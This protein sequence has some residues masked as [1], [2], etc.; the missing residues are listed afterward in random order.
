M[1][2]FLLYTLSLLAACSITSC[3]DDDTTD[4]SSNRMFMTTFRCDNNTGKGDSDP[5]N[6]TIQ[7]LNDAHLYWYTVDGAAGYRIKWALMP[8]VSGGKEAWEEAEANGNLAGDTIVGPD[9]VDLLIK[10]LDYQTDYRFAIQTLHS[11]DKDDPA[12]SKWYGYGD[13]R[14]WA[15]YLGLQ[16]SSRYIVPSVIQA[17]NITK[18]AVRI[19]LNRSANGYSVDE[20]TSFNE[21]FTNDGQNFKVD[22]LTLEASNS[23]PDAKVPAEFARYQLTDQDWNRGYVDIEGLSENSVYVINV[24]D[25]DIKVKVDACYNTLMKRTKGDAGPAILIKHVATM[26]DT[27]GIG[28]N[29]TYYDISAY[30]SMKLDNILND[31]C[32]SNTLA[33][34]QVFYL[35][36]GKTYHCTTNISIYK[37]FTLRTNPKDLA[38]GKGKATLLLNGI[39]QTGTKVN[40]CNFMLGRQPQSGE[41]SSIALD[42]DSVRFMDLNIDVPLAKNYG[43]SQDGSNYSA[44]GNY[45]MNMYSNGMG[46]N[47]NLLEWNNCTFNGLIR[48]FFR[49]QGSNDFYI[50]NL[51][52]TDCVFYN[53]GYYSNNGSGYQIIFAD[54]NGKPKSNILENVDINNNVFYNSPMGSLV[55]DKNR[56]L[57]W[58]ESVR[59]NIS[60]TNNTFINFQ[61][62][63]SANPIVNFR[64]MPGGS[65]LTIKNNYITV[66]ASENDPLRGLLSK[67]SD[68]RNIQGGD[69]SGIVTFDVGNNWTTNNNLTAGQ[70]FTSNAFS[71]K[72]NSIGKFLASC[73]YPMGA[74]ELTVHVDDLSATELMVSPNPKH[75]IGE[76][77]N[78]LDH[79]T[80]DI[81]D[82]NIQSSAKAQQSNIIKLGI[83]ARKWREN[84]LKE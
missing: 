47:V 52:M 46:I 3:S 15:D 14:Q 51:K 21:H 40:T 4:A 65:T 26:T 1:K 36:G 24:W 11:L 41:N 80:E 71:A 45:F 76:I 82:I 13:G 66:T 39:T 54:H 49:I 63:S 84:R 43:H 16:T 77:A 74:D 70:P 68:I 60:I 12:N 53:D 18:T 27:M 81:N 8:Y 58:D 75:I 29:A 5:Y 33:E 57:M 34:N 38:D 22:Y 62:R 56:N 28:E 20:M 7:D 30:K 59:W 72:S 55:T 78:H 19:N 37:G 67:G 64:Y 2:K 79:Y 61:T 17:S 10:D 6:C 50:H 69:G 73:I 31:Y 44:S 42:I 83:G 9:Q 23:S 35:E 48:G 25:K 32:A